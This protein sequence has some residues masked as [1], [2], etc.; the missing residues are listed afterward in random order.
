[1][2]LACNE[3]FELGLT[4]GQLLDHARRL[5][6]DVGYALGQQ[7]AIVRGLGDEIEPVAHRPLDL[8]LCVPDAACGTGAVYQAF[9]ELAGDG[10]VG[11][12]DEVGRLATGPLDASRLFNDLTGGA[13][14]VCEELGPLTEQI[15]AVAEAPVHMSGS[16]S[17]LFIVCDNDMHAELLAAAVR[18]R[19]GIPALAVQTVEGWSDRA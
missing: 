10:H 18:D 11:Q 4:S 6:S 12:F 14:A 3:L 7:A 5:G 19:L 9:D 17:S 1:M 16:G 8:V 13:H 15:A 2:L